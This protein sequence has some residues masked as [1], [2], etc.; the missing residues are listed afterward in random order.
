VSGLLQ[1]EN[2]DAT[3]G[4]IRAL[5]SVSLGVQAGEIVAVVGANGMGK[6]TL[7]RTIS[8]IVPVCG[9][10]IRFE[11]ESIAGLEPE[12]IVLRG[13]SHVPERRELF[14]AMT[15][16]ENLELGAYHRRGRAGRPE[17][18]R[19]LEGIW[20]LFPILRARQGQMAGTLSGGEQQMLAIARGLMA[21]PKLL[22]L[23]EPSLGLSPLLVQ[24]VL[25]FVALLREMG[26]TVLL[27]EQNASGAL[28]IADHAYLMEV[29]R[30]VLHGTAGELLE[31][32]KVRRAYLGQRIAPPRRP[33]KIELLPQHVRAGA[34]GSA[35]SQRSTFHRARKGEGSAMPM[36]SESLPNF[37][38]PDEYFEERVGYTGDQ[39]RAIQD[40]ALPRAFAHAFEHS[41]YYQE[42]FAAAGLTP[43]SIR[44]LHDL[45]RL[46]FTTSEEIRPSPTSTRTSAVLLSKEQTE[47]CL[48]HTSSGTTGAP[49]IFAYTGRDVARWAANTATVFW[50]NGFRKSDVMLGVMPFGEFTGGGG[51]YLGM[52]A[53]G[54][55]YLPMSLAAGVTTKVLA[56]LTGRVQINDHDVLIDPILRA[57][58]LLC[59]G[60]FLPRLEEMLDEHDVSPNELSL[61]KITCGAE[62]SSDAAR[63]RIA[64]RFGI[65]PRDNYGLGE[66]YGP[67][68]AGECEAGGGLHV[69]SDAFIA[70]VLDPEGDEPTP[71]GEMGELV[72]T[73]LHKD[74]MPLLR[75]R[76]GDRVMALPQN[77]G[78]GSAHTW[79]GRVPGRIS[80]DDIM[81]PGGVVVNR[82]YLEDTL[83][84]VDGAGAEYVL[85]VGE[86]PTRKGLQRLYIAIEGDPESDLAETIEHRIQVE[87][88]H[89]PLVTVVPNGS[90]PRR[91]GKA[92]RILTP[93]EY[94]AVW[95]RATGN[96]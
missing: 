19:D 18:Q 39:I 17:V 45:R 49:K 29:G 70:E 16:L 56:H 27:V 83:L 94:A 40:E 37:T 4:P 68:V 22:L 25:R 61:T 92:K 36:L 58:A 87:Y 60:S 12:K 53:L 50:I 73:S 13:I 5:H 72:L 67:G 10:D 3:Y 52:I 15:V 63:M 85:T 51:L 71:I 38:L 44:G 35:G 11:G 93:E 96:R 62:P 82:T 6:T 46:P 32:P 21:R 7:L 78:C 91:A 33:D 41:A 8:G 42:K 55:T 28:Q 23:D 88:N 77:C 89:S 84:H 90:I 64:E 1:I 2:L 80:T 59:L 34:G 26:R 86:H 75:Y 65:W 74:A 30:I 48:V 57:N 47:V 31:D 81:I 14:S 24:E 43:D 95:T 66:F 20:E 76:T 69:L 79:I 54:L 9:G